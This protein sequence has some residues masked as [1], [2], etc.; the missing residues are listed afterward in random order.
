MLKVESML[1][2][3]FIILLAALEAAGRKGKRKEIF[4]QNLH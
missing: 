1:N 3:F 4:K 2:D